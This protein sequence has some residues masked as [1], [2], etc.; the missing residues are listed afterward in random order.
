MVP[1]ANADWRQLVRE[2]HARLSR[3]VAIGDVWSLPCCS[4]PQITISSVRPLR[5]VYDGTR[6]RL[7]RMQL[8]ERLA[9]AD[10]P[11]KPKTPKAAKAALAQLAST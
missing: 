10:K 6:Y 11:R 7:K 3:T 1:E 2:H 9:Q 8:G 4:I 5:G